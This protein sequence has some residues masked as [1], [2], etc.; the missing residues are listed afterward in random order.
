MV[1]AQLVLQLLQVV[2]RVRTTAIEAYK[3][4]EV[5]FSQVV[6]ALQVPPDPSRSPVYQC[7]LTFETRRDSFGG[8]RGGAGDEGGIDQHRQH[9]NVQVGHVIADVQRPRFV[10]RRPVDRHPQGRKPRHAAKPQQRHTTHSESFW[11][12]QNH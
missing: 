6:S 12:D 8:R 5:P 3:H 7:A 4:A 2:T 11:A 1:V 9:R 10:H